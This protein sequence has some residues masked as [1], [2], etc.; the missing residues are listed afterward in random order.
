[1][2]VSHDTLVDA[3]CR[4]LRGRG[5]CWVVLAE[6][7]GIGMEIPDAIGWGSRGHSTLVEAKI[8]R[9]DFF[10][11]AG[12]PHRRADTGMGAERYYLTPVG[13]VGAQDIPAGWGWLEFRNGRVTSRR[14]AEV[15]DLQPDACRREASLLVNE[16]SRYQRCNVKYPHDWH[17]WRWRVDSHVGRA[18]PSW[19]PTE[20]LKLLALQ[21]QAADAAAK[22]ASE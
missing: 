22:G 17:I 16:L 21:G 4:W 5:R 18:E 15:R 14:K 10:A 12:K 11:D 9:A 13:L 7:S 3:A 20:R 8:S 2:G 19:R 6:R 1:M